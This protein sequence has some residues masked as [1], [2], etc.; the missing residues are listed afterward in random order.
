[1]FGVTP[2]RVARRSTGSARPSISKNRIPGTS[3]VTRSPR[4]RDPSAYPE[5][6]GVV[7]TCPEDHLEDH[8]HR[9][10]HQ[11]SQQ[12]PTEPIDLDRRRV[13]V[14]REEQNHPIEQQ[15]Q[16]EP[17]RERERET[18]RGH[19]R[20]KHGVE[21][22]DH[23]RGHGCVSEGPDSE[24]GQDGGGDEYCDGGHEPDEQQL[25]NAKPRR[26]RCPVE[27]GAVGRNS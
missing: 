19:E 18:E 7:V 17:E 12:R 6:V 25:R 4:P 24:P 21:H 26:L 2:S 9:G 10:D 8:D 5:Q 11:R 13:D 23:K 20:R 27:C 3:V 1:M 16:H 22:P 15:H 14:R